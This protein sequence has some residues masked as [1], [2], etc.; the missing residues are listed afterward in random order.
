M[1]DLSH[2]RRFGCTAYVH[3][4]QEKTKP[5]TVKGVFVGYPFG[6]KGYRVWIPEELKCTT[7]RNVVFREDELYKDAQANKSTDGK[8]ES[9]ETNKLAKNSK[10]KVSFSPSL[11]RGPSGPNYEHGETFDPGNTSV[12][13]QESDYS[14]SS[15]E[16]ESDDETEDLT[17]VEDTESASS[18]DNYMLARDRVRRQ[19]VGP[20]SRYEY[21]NLVDYALEVADDIER[22]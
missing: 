1:S 11:I 4:T 16:S 2:L 17:F 22:E 7:S 10:K 3:V 13:Q 19:N 9:V 8:D 6:V 12:S 14:G 15:S 5:R 18:V 21:A 20:P